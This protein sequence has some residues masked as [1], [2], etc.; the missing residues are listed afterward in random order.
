[1]E[2]GRFDPMFGYGLGHFKR[3]N[4]LPRALKGLIQ[5]TNFKVGLWPF[6]LGK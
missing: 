1:M 4:G 3:S 5:D 2:S 6:S